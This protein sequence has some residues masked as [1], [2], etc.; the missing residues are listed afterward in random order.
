MVRRLILMRHAKS[1]WAD[2]DAADID[3]V[4]NCRGRK[5]CKAV[6]R[7]LR[8]EGQ[9]PDQVLCSSAAR[10]RETWDRIAA[11]LRDPPAVTEVPA[12]KSSK[13]LNFSASAFLII[14]DGPPVSK[15]LRQPGHLRPR[16]KS[17]SAVPAH[18]TGP[19]L[20]TLWTDSQ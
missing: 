11:E 7:W 8:D 6:G 9:I 3:R 10:T 14:R 4:L 5:S 1:S 17:R 2:D 18:Q 12:P 16:Q 13:L 15:L 20:F 19:L